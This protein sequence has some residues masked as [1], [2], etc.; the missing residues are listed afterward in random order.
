M[1]P[2]SLHERASLDLLYANRPERDRQRK[3]LPNA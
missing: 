2:H 3:V 1:Q